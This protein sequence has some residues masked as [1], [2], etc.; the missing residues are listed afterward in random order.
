MSHLGLLGV[1]RQ[2][3]MGRLEPLETSELVHI[4]FCLMPKAGTVLGSNWPGSPSKHQ[5]HTLP[6]TRLPYKTNFSSRATERSSSLERGLRN[7]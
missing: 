5:D 1:H 3:S 4:G 2:A 6:T 7:M